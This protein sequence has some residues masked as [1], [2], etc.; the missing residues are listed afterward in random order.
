[1]DF[2]HDSLWNGRKIRCLTIVDLYGRYSPAIEVGFSLSGAQVIA[3]LE[4]LAFL[5]GVPEVITVDN[6]P[7]FVCRALEEWAKRHGVKLDFIEPGKPTQNGFVESFN[8]TFRYECLDSHC[9]FSLL[10]ARTRIEK[11]RTEYNTER[12]HSSLG[13]VT[14]EMFEAEF[15]QN[16]ALRKGNTKF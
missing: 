8:G 15:F 16:S 13:N 6:G 14:P 3:T 4:K 9:F 11:W 2:V 12:P 7:E 5:R 10:D 1:M